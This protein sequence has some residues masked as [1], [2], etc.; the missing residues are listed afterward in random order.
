MS[1]EEYLIGRGGV[2]NV[3][4]NHLLLEPS[5][6]KMPYKLILSGG[7]IWFIQY[8]IYSM[9]SSFFPIKSVYHHGNDNINTNNIHNIDIYGFGGIIAL[10]PLISLI[11]IPIFE[12]YTLI[13]KIGLSKCV[14]FG[15]L[16]QGLL[17][18]FF[19]FI[20]S[21][22]N[23]TKPGK[24]TSSEVA[25]YILSCILRIFSSILSVL[26]ELSI[27]SIITQVTPRKVLSRQ[28]CM[29]LF[30]MIGLMTGPFLS[31]FLYCLAFGTDYE[32]QIT[33]T[34]IGCLIIISSVIVKLF[35][36][37]KINSLQDQHVN[38]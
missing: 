9:L 34:I 8:M 25:F 16:L 10:S 35:I 30:C 33:F 32:Y 5:A 28:Q 17:C 14:V 4:Y 27:I 2:H 22:T 37:P 15:L 18:I 23:T 36:P 29:P 24:S 3:S 13:Y 11:L 20:P 7:I 6:E 26:I 21:I 19:G 38:I 1:D 31:G 12:K